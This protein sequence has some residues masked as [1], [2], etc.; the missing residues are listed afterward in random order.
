MPNDAI[1]EDIREMLKYNFW[2]PRM[3]DLCLQDSVTKNPRF[4]KIEGYHC[5]ERAARFFNSSAGFFIAFFSGW[6]T[7]TQRARRSAGPC[8][9]TYCLVQPL[10][11]GLWRSSGLASSGGFCLFPVM[12]SM[13]SYGPDDRLA[14]EIVVGDRSKV[15]S[16]CHTCC[17]R[18]CC[19]RP[20]LNFRHFIWQANRHVVFKKGS[21]RCAVSRR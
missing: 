11:A 9:V 20:V 12:S 3:P 7:H 21:L 10:R 8:S 18:L 17:S 1:V 13:P 14:V 5:G 15:M 6:R 19:L 4:Q 16:C 2:D